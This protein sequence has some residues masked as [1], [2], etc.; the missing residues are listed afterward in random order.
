MTLGGHSGWVGWATV[1]RKVL[2]VEEP[3][4]YFDSRPE[5]FGC[6]F[7]TRY[8][9]GGSDIEFDHTNTDHLESSQAVGSI[10]YQTRF[11][12]AAAGHSL[13]CAGDSQEKS[14]K[15]AA[16]TAELEMSDTE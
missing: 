2:P 16:A 4:D 11:Q 1:E 13:H 6:A 15:D 14:R 10:G 5:D 9:L 12:V 8:N 7:A 3:I